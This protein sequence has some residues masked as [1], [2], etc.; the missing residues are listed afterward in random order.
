L[1]AFPYLEHVENIADSMSQPP[2]PLPQSEMY[3]GVSAPLIDYIAEPWER[4]AQ[5][6]LEMNLQINP[7][8]PFATSNK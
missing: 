8:Y 4:D 7:Y 6:C 3:P 1:D 5:G 2:L